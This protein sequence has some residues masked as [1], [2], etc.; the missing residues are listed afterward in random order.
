MITQYCVLLVITGLRP[1]K[2]T[3]TDPQTCFG[4]WLHLSVCGFHRL[5]VLCGTILGLY[6][7]KI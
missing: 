5:L 1:G 3:D 2:G 7:Q 6:W 4:L